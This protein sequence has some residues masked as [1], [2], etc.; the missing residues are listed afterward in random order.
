MRA[1]A[2]IFFLLSSDGLWIIAVKIFS[3]ENV[4][5]TAEYLDAI[6]EIINEKGIG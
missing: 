3:G 6:T 1:D 5:H 2:C 4:T